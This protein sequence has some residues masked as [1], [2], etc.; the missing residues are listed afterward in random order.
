L[1]FGF[2]FL[3]FGF[4]FGFGFGFSEI[5]ESNSIHLVLSDEYGYFFE[6]PILEVWYM[7]SSI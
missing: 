4:G 2:W 7:W 3:V 5:I 1:V 6:L